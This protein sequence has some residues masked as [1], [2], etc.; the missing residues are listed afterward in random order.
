[1]L[2]LI[3]GGDGML[4]HKVLQVLSRRSDRVCCSIRGS[5]DTPLL[6]RTGLFPP[7]RTL[8]G[9]DALDL[10]ALRA[11]ITGLRPDWI[12]NCIGVIKQ[13]EAA[14]LAIPSI[15]I[16]ALL[17]HLLADWSSQWGG[18]VVHFSTDCVFSG[19]RGAYT[20]ADVSDAEDLYG[21]SKFLGEVD[22]GNA[23]VLRTSIIGREL[24][25]FASLLEWFLSQQ[26]GPL[27]GYRRALWSGVT[28]GWLAGLVGRVIDVHPDL[29][30]LYQVASQPIDKWSLLTMLRDAYGLTTR[31]DPD[32]TLAIDRTLS[33]RR[34]E[35]ATGIVVPTWPDLIGELISDPTPYNDWR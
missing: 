22:A 21:R 9:V 28:T 19:R 32:D 4:G 34:F 6:R 30:G 10:G 13:R 18:R 7:E 31:I 17:P 2:I 8:E 12:V 3:L 15:T 33:G 20:E 35:E 23:L 27:R 14:R 11:R 1:M 24:S 29:H 26:Q 16:N 5:L 25:R